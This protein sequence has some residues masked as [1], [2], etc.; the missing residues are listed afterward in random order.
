[1]LFPILVFRSLLVN[2]TIVL[3][4]ISDYLVFCENKK[5]LTRLKIK[6]EKN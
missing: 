6:K 5:V 1:M 3:L 2:R 4:I